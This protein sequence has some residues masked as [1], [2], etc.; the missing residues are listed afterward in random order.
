[1]KRDRIKQKKEKEDIEAYK[2]GREIKENC[3]A[4]KPA[5][6]QRRDAGCWHLARGGRLSPRQSN[7]IMF[8]V[9]GNWIR[10]K[11]VFHRRWSLFG[12]GYRQLPRF[13]R[14]TGF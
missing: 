13:A 8:G 9:C 4:D 1:M 7:Q 2:N 5:C 10:K 6:L 3:F 12:D 11:E 14:I